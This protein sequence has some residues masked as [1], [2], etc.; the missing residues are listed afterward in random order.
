VIATLYPVVDP[1]AHRPPDGDGDAAFKT[2]ERRREFERI[3]GWTWHF[4]PGL[5]REF[6]LADK[7]EAYQGAGRALR[8]E[9]TPAFYHPISSHPEWAA[10]AVVIELALR[11]LVAALHDR[12]PLLPAGLA[13]EE[14]PHA[15]ISFGS[16]SGW[17]PLALSIRMAGFERP[18]AG[19]GLLGVFRRTTH[20]ELREQDVPWPLE[21]HECRCPSAAAMWRWARGNLPTRAEAVQHLGAHD[22]EQ[23]PRQ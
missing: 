3:V 11:S 12:D 2:V 18:N 22:D 16:A 5:L 15:A 10:W 13:A 4:V 23:Q 14:S 9:R 7:V 1:L 21:T 17:L 8:T 19:S 6:A 20:W